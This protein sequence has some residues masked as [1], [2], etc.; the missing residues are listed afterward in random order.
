MKDSGVLWFGE[1][2]NSWERVKIGH[3]TRRKRVKAN[4]LGVV[5]AFRDGQVTLRSN[6]RMDGFTEATEFHGYQLIRPGQ[7][8]VHR[9]D[10][11]AGAIGVSDSEG[12]CSP[13]LTV[14]DCDRRIDPHYLALVLREAAKSG[15]IEALAKSIRERTSEFGWSELSSQY[16]LVPP[17]DVQ[18]EIV[19]YLKQETSQIDLLISKKE[20]LIEKLLERRQALIT[21]VV[22]KGLDPN[23]TM[24]DS[25][26]DWLGKVPK[27]WLVLP[28]KAVFRAT[29][30]K[31]GHAEEHL[32]PSQ[33]FGVLS[34]KDYMQISRSRVVLQSTDSGNMKLVLPGDFISHLRSFQGGLEVSS[35]RGKVSGAYTVLRPL[36]KH[37][38]GYFKW[39]LKSNMYVQGLQ[40]TTDQLRDGQT[41]RMEQLK[42]LPLPFPEPGEQAYIASFLNQETSQ[43]DTLVK[44]TMK[45][46]ELLRERR[47]AL[48]TQVV[49]GKIDV[50]GFTGGNS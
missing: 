43:I 26:V 28:A 13:V 3:L 18:K 32:T 31:A 37:E 1:T 30:T 44:K 39:L 38:S 36:R 2:P 34:Q 21:Y 4:D 42:L 27:D 48:I 16:S 49:T 17:I 15:W 50:R 14:L 23:A 35:L 46:I 6:R 33:K 47:Q 45:A 12:M 22:T 40:T 10:A 25:G 5:T 11:F 9:M 7:V 29:S 19:S 24:K 20:Q 41:I 8:A